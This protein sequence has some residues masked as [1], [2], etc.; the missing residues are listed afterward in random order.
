MPDMAAIGA[1]GAARTITLVLSL[2][3]AVAAAGD[4]A[5]KTRMQKSSRTPASTTSALVPARPG[6]ATFFTINAVLAKL[7]G[8]SAS[9]G[10]LVAAAPPT[11]TMSDAART[12]A[13]PPVGDEPFSL[14]A[15]RAPEGLLWEKWRALDADITHEAVVIAGCRVAPQDCTSQAAVR[16]IALTDDLRRR[17]GRDRLDVAN[18]T[19]NA[20]IRYMSDHAEHGVAD[21]W[22]A[23][24]A[25]FAS[26]LGDCEDYAIA[27]YVALRDAGTPAD[28]LR[29]LLVRDA[30]TR[31]DHAVLAARQDGQW[32]ILDNR[33]AALVAD[34]DAI[35]LKPLFA[36]GGDGVK[37]LA[38]PYVSENGES[39]ETDMIPATAEWG[40]ASAGGGSALLLLL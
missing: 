39:G 14:F 13:L 2:A 21:R 25:T 18:G 31:E 4:A 19:V 3:V 38:A 20:A 1:L 32:L 34:G 24:L 28:D 26:G 7:D 30:A 17:A 29:L 5:A 12:P 40:A 10:P 37:L 22:S 11:G 16:F 35:S 9:P 33:R 27:K 8:L 15:F 36:I 23:P 6:P